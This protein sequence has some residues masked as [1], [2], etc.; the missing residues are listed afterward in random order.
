M[1]VYAV[2]I[3]ASGVLTA[4]RGGVGCGKWLGVERDGGG[5]TCRDG[6]EHG[7][8]PPGGDLGKVG[9]GWFLP[10]SRKRGQSTL[11]WGLVFVFWCDGW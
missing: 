10:C 8:R 3:V 9:G 7:G 4:E 2:L 5:A 6:R 1:L 11:L